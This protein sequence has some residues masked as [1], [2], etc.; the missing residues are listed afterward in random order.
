MHG[1]G[2]HGRWWWV[3]FEVVV[4]LFQR[5]DQKFVET[6]KGAVCS[7]IVIRREGSY[8]FLCP[9]KLNLCFHV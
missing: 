6:F 3:L 5:T 2:P 7:F 4:S 8:F 9:N 1:P